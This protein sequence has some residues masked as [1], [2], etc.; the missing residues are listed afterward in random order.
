[1]V[2]EEL[3]EKVELAGL[4][5]MYSE[6]G[7]VGVGWREGRAVGEWRGGGGGTGR[8]EAVLAGEVEAV[9]LLAHDGRG[10]ED[11]GFEYYGGV[12]SLRPF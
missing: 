10:V 7:A 12:V 3:S 6:G 11:M 2:V 4:R 9:G 5:A 1:M 8:G